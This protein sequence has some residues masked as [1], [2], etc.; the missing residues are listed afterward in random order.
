MS[1]YSIPL[2]SVMLLK[3][4]LEQG[5]DITCKLQRPEATVVAQINVENDD[6]SH[7]IKVTLGPRASTL[8]LPRA[9]ATKYQRL[10]DFLQDLANGRDESGSL[11]EEAIALV[12]AQEIVEGVILSGQRVYIIPTINPSLP[13]GAV[14][15]NDSG[16]VCAAATGR[17]K[18]HLAEVVRAKLRPAR[19]GAGEYA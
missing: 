11:S 15:T 10:R 14:V 13:L 18:E 2:H 7:H 5:G 1:E 17:D 4:T 8:T 19:E 9:P 6:S 3:H 16:E 12:E